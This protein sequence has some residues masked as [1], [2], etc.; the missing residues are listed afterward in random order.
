MMKNKQLE[1]TAKVNVYASIDHLLMDYGF[2]PTI[3]KP[4]H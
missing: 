4:K 2:V 3:L 1:K